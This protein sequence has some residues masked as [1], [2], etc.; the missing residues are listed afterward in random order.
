MFNNGEADYSTGILILCLR[1]SFQFNIPELDCNR[2]QE[3]TNGRTK[4]KDYII[5]T[6]IAENQANVSRVRRL[7]CSAV[8][9]NFQNCCLLFKWVQ[10]GEEINRWKKEG[11][12]DDCTANWKAFRQTGGGDTNP[13]TGLKREQRKHTGSVYF[14][15][16][17]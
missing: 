16:Q 10:N 5:K 2:S 15:S 6:I 11:K 9:E 3:I 7:V 8:L 4:K 17:G 1:D 13:E 12:S 14:F